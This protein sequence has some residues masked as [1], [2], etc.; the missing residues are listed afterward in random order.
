MITTIG[1]L[2]DAI[3]D[4]KDEDPIYILDHMICRSFEIDTRTILDEL[5][6]RTK[7]VIVL[8]KRDS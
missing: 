2:R 4:Y 1:E 7:S 6:R 5:N 3:R 8:I